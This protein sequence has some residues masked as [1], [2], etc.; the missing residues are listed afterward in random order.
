M[1]WEGQYGV[2]WGSHAPPLRVFNYRPK[3]EEQVP[4]ISC[5]KSPPYS[6][7]GKRKIFSSPSN[8]PANERQ[9]QL[10]Q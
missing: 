3:R 6:P 2:G 10:D 9:S 7:A 1:E 8:R 5:W 4:Y